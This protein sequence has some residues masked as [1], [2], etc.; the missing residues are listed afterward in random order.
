MICVSANSNHIEISCFFSSTHR[1]SRSIC[2]NIIR[3]CV[4]AV[5]GYDHV[6]LSTLREVLTHPQVILFKILNINYYGQCGHCV[7]ANERIMSG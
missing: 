3:Q 1:S 7:V 6:K 2:K 5:T 4:F